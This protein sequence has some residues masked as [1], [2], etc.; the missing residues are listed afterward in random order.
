MES[1]GLASS[2]DAATSSRLD[3]PQLFFSLSFPSENDDVDVDGF[4]R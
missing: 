3:Y 4:S 1:S 2:D